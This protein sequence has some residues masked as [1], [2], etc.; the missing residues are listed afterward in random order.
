MEQIQLPLLYVGC[1]FITVASGY[2]SYYHYRRFIHYQKIKDDIY[3]DPSP[4][5]ILNVSQLHNLKLSPN[6]YYF[7]N[8]ITLSQKLSTDKLNQ[9]NS[10]DQTKILAQVISRHSDLIYYYFFL[11]GIGG[12]HFY[13]D[14]VNTVQFKPS[15]KYR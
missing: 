7:V 15:I 2:L 12:Q 5:T 11:W 9:L 8:G 4:D 1:G 3:G 6:K 13:Y 10:I 14:K